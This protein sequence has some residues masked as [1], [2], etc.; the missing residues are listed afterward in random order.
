LPQPLLKLAVAI[1][2]F[3]ILAGQL[4]QLVFKPLDPHF[5]IGIVGLR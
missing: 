3:L 2:Q 5:E 1:L 4:P